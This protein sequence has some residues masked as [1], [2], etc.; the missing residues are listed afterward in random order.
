MEA[1]FI[2]WGIFLTLLFS[3]PFILPLV[4]LVAAL[5]PAEPIEPDPYDLET[6]DPNKHM[7]LE[8]PTTEVGPFIPRSQ[9]VD[10]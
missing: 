9:D 4:M 1:I 5:C 10:N 2:S 7:A 3:L 8:G 6:L